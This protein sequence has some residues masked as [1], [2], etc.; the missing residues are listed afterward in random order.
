LEFSKKY[1]ADYLVLPEEFTIKNYYP[2]DLKKVFSNPSF[3]L[4]QVIY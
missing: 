3:S 1:I 2:A 4:F